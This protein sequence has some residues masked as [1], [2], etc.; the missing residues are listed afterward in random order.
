LDHDPA[1]GLDTSHAAANALGSAEARDRAALLEQMTA[2]V[3]HDLRNPLSTI[4]MSVVGLLRMDLGQ[5][6]RGAVERIERAAQLATA[7]VDDL[8]EF[9]AAVAGT[10]LVVSRQPI[11]LHATAATAVDDIRARHPART[12]THAATGSGACFGAADRIAE[13][14]ER[15]GAFALS[16]AREGTVVEIASRFED[17]VPCIEVRLVVEPESADALA[18]AVEPPRGRQAGGLRGGLALGVVVARQIA[19]AHG[20]DLSVQASADGA[21]SFRASLGAASKA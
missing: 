9:A 17:G 7:M 1:P 16:R 4:V 12:L 20:G 15:I 2:I 11:D 5:R 10:D 8:Q 19:R 6:P 3:G 13:L 18:A 14:V 21:V